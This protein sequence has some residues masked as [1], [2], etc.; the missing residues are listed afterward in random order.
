MGQA[1]GA[2]PCYNAGT[3]EPLSLF[4]SSI[5]QM[6]CFVKVPGLAAL[7]TQE[8]YVWQLIRSCFPSQFASSMGR[9]D[10]ASGWACVSPRWC[11]QP[12]CPH[13]HHQHQAA[14]LAVLASLCL[15]WNCS[16]SSCFPR[17]VLLLCHLFFLTPF[18]SQTA[19][20]GCIMAG[21]RP[22]SFFLCPSS[23]AVARGRLHLGKCLVPFSLP[24]YWAISEGEIPCNFGCIFVPLALVRFCGYVSR[25]YLL[26]CL[27]FFSC[28]CFSCK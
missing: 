22:D 14:A 16:T 17:K 18:F 12:G 25:D 19:K 9:E 28:Y 27:G 3:P 5:C 21:W 11:W 4:S 8:K 2:G 23:H 24:T 20:P 10:W 13:C 6:L 26:G 7:A 1:G 15:P